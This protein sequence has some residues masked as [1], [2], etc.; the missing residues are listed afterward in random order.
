MR[1]VFVAAAALLAQFAGATSSNA[2]CD[3]KLAKPI[4][5]KVSNEIAIM[6]QF[7]KATCFPSDDGGKCSLL[8]ASDL[9]ISGMNRNI[10][11]TFITASAGKKMR[12]AGIGR[13]S[14][15]LF[16]DLNLLEKRRALKLAAD[17]ASTLQSGFAATTEKPEV[18]AARVGNEYSE[19]D[20]SKK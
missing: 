11:L 20:F 3:P 9:R 16:A 13:F 14:S 6:I 15:I 1:E 12:D 10:V 7:T 19:I 5:D 17:R 4:A 18:M 2:A 8:C